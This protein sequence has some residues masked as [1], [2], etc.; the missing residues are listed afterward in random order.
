M[1]LSEPLERYPRRAGARNPHCGSLRRRS[2]ALDRIRC[3][4]AREHRARS[5]RARPT[6]G[7]TGAI[8]SRPT[9]SRRSPTTCSAIGCCSASR[10]KPT[11]STRTAWSKHCSLDGGGAL[12]AERLPRGLTGGDVLHR[13]SRRPAG[14]CGRPL[15]GCTSL[16]PS[17]SGRD[18]R[19][20][21]PGS[22]DGILGV[23]DL[24]ARRRHPQHRLAGDRAH[25][26]GPYQALPGGARPPGLLRRGPWRTHAIRHPTGVQV[27][28]GGRGR[29]VARMGRGGER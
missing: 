28:G 14:A 16:P 17:R 1:H 11:A 3:Q 13:R 29:L 9:T 23:E 10:P 19:I 25:R 5:L 15:P 18:A 12:S 22:R 2:R 8:T 21:A 27:G 4:P 7:W 6:H 26:P 24:P 20:A